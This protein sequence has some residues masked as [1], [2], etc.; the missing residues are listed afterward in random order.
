MGWDICLQASIGEDTD[1][2]KKP[3]KHGICLMAGQSFFDDFDPKID[4]VENWN[5]LK[6]V[7]SLE[8]VS[9]Q[10]N[11]RQPSSFASAFALRP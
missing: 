5:D 8:E 7:S 3:F 10:A 9:C 11:C 4:V 1:F 6:E 2:V